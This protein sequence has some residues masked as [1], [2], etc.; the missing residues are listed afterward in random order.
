MFTKWAAFGIIILTMT[1]D[2][3]IHWIYSGVVVSL[4]NRGKGD[5]Q[6]S[7]WYFYDEEGSE[8]QDI[9][10]SLMPFIEPWRP[11]TGAKRSNPYF[12]SSIASNRMLTGLWPRQG[13]H[14]ER[15]W[16]NYCSSAHCTKIANPSSVSFRYFHDGKMNVFQ[17]WYTWLT[18]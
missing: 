15:V 10:K 1:E 17:N 7:P 18:L 14:V 6:C 16:Q 4:Q 5:Y 13:K 2:K 8:Y 11:L 9:I 12:L 3:S